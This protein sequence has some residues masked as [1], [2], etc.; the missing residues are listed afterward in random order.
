M[1]Q[2]SLV[3]FCFF[4]HLQTWLAPQEHEAWP[5]LGSKSKPSWSRGSSTAAETTKAWSPRSY[6]LFSL[7]HSPWA[8][9]P[10]IMICATILS[11]S[12][13]PLSTASDQ[14][15]LFSGQSSWRTGWRV[16]LT[17]M[18]KKTSRT[19]FVHKLYVSNEC[20]SRRH[21]NRSSTSRNKAIWFGW[22]IN[23][24]LMY[25]VAWIVSTCP[26]HHFWGTTKSSIFKGQTCPNGGNKDG[27]CDVCRCDA[28]SK[29][30]SKCQ[31]RL[32]LPREVPLFDQG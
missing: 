10:S 21:Q 26:S 15:T 5:S 19:W 12:L 29:W 9:D 17:G 6:F 11:C 31:R 25:L 2:F 7:S 8:W 3:F 24:G 23:E 14:V 22:N 16:V 13:A 20:T 1:T 4:S 27:E 32:S 18:R 30:H 28:R